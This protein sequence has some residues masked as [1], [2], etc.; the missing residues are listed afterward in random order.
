MPTIHRQDGFRFYFYSHEPNEPAH[1]HGDRSG[2][3]VKVWLTSVSVAH[4]MG[5][6][7]KDLAELLRI[8]REHRVRFLEEWHGFFDSQD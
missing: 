6:S 4:D 5:H 8:V 3:S 1:V 2:A 7:A